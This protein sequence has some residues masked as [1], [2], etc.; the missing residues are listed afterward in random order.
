MNAVQS[1]DTS[2]AS[3]GPGTLAA[4]EE[5]LGRALLLQAATAIEEHVESTA[6]SLIRQALAIRQHPDI[7]ELAALT[8]K[9][10]TH[11]ASLAS[12]LEAT[13]AEARP[14][15]GAGAL[16]DWSQ[17]QADGPADGPLGN[18]SYARQLALVARNMLQALDV[19]RDGIP[20]R[21]P[22]IG[23]PTLPPLAPSPG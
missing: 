2:E 1:P 18:W 13:P 15:R 20:A 23:R 9:L 6:L 19:H 14:A 22:Y 4:A 21:A 16:R 8:D 10:L 3:L 11:C 7:H 5:D 17:L 12:E